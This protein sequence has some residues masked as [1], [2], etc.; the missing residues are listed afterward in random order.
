MFTSTS[1]MM[2]DLPAGAKPQFSYLLKHNGDGT[3]IYANADAGYFAF[4]MY[5]S[6]AERMAFNT[7]RQEILKTNADAGVPMQLHIQ[8]DWHWLCL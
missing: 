3:G 8:G 6:D 5:A 7:K 4:A 2:K 1:A